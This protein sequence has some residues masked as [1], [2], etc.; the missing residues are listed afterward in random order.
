LQLHSSFHLVSVFKV[1]LVLV[2]LKE[3]CLVL[4][5][6]NRYQC[7]TALALASQAKLVMSWSW[8]KF[9]LVQCECK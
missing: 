5:L 2:L 9:A 8:S 3:I 6:V 4:V 7:N 1:F